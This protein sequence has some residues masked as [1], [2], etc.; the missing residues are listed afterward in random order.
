MLAPLRNVCPMLFISVARS[1]RASLSSSCHAFKS[2]W[3][4]QRTCASRAA[5]NWAEW[6]LVSR[7]QPRC[8]ASTTHTPHTAL[9]PLADT[10]NSAGISTS[11][12]S[13]FPG[14]ELWD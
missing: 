1:T 6:E 11:R 2:L 14:S 4:V 7:H 9:T 3:R 12:S 8:D 13:P 5:C 10:R